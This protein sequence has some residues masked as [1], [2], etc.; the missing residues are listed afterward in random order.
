LTTRPAWTS[1][2]GMIR[3]ESIEFGGFG[4]RDGAEGLGTFVTPILPP[5][6]Q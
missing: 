4:V 6:V 3:F 1:R 5:D 2:Q